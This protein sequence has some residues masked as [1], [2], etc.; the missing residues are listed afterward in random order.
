MRLQQQKTLFFAQGKSDKV[1]EISLL[2]AGDDLFVVN[3]RY[4]RRGANLQEGTKTV[5]PVPYDE[6]IKV[7]NKLIESKVKKGYNENVEESG[8]K[9]EP[10]NSSPI[11]NSAQEKTILKYLRQGSQGTYTRSWKMSRILWKAGELRLSSAA[12]L[13]DYFVFSE[14]E[15][16]QYSAIYALQKIGPEDSLEKILKVFHLK[17]FEDKSGRI[18]AA[19]I[20]LSNNEAYISAVVSAAKQKL[21]FNWQVIFT[22]PEESIALFS[23]YYFKGGI[24][25]E[26]VIYY[27]YLASYNNKK[28]REQLFIFLQDIPLKVNSFKSIRYIFRA[29]EVL[30]DVTFFALIAKRIAISPL[31][32]EAQYIYIDRKYVSVYKEKQKDNPSIAFSAKTR[33][34]FNRFIYKF[35]LKLSIRNEDDFVHF[36]KELF[37]LLDD[38]VDNQNITSEYFYDL[39][40]GRYRQKKRYFPKY[41]SFLGLM[42]V[43]YGGS[44]RIN[45]RKNKFYFLD[46]LNTKGESRDEI[47]PDIWN[48]RPLDVLSILAKSKSDVVINFAISIIEDNEGFVDQVTDD[49]LGQLIGHYDNR[50][51]NLFLQ[52]VENRYANNQAPSSIIIS[53]LSATSHKANELGLNWL[54]NDESH[55]FINSM[56]ISELLLSRKGF[57]I[58]YLKNMYQEQ[59]KYHL[60]ID[61]YLLEPLFRVPTNYN[62]DY[63]VEVCSLIG[64]T[65]FGKLLANTPVERIT[66]LSKSNI[67]NKLFALNLSKHNR[68]PAYE[69]FKDSYNEYISSD[70]LLLRKAGIELLAFFPD[71]FLLEQQNT[72]VKYCF[73]EHPEVREAIL[74]TVKRLTKIDSGFDKKFLAELLQSIIV[75]ETHE[76]IHESNYRLIIE[77]YGSYISSIDKKGIMELLLSKYEFAQKVGFPLFQ[78]KVIIANLDTDQ[79]VSLTSCDIL[80]VRKMVH[81]FFEEHVSRINFE[82]E[83]A[84]KIFNSEWQDVINWGCEY[85]ERNIDEKNWTIDV[86][87]SVCDHINPFVQSFG[88]RM[89]SIYFT[90]DKG[91]PLLLKLQEHPTKEMQFFVTNY[92]DGFAKDSP[93]VILKM[94]SYFKTSLFNINTNRPT[95]ERIYSFLEQESI[96]NINV[97]EMTIRIIDSILGTKTK[98]DISHNIDLL[99]LINES[100]P[101]LDIPLLINPV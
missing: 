45:I 29:A 97:A 33:H 27:T 4:G 3:F 78:E 7:Y 93:D 60:S 17:G 8:L 96:K 42:Y 79:I 14:D 20:L 88:R 73:S 11:L 21:P 85:F 61:I 100:H 51:A 91:L 41:H 15:F 70:E 66:S 44:N 56:F 22:H 84:L 5:F 6:A 32:Y 25:D 89:I 58:G 80:D 69:I 16:E 26:Y 75:A 82:L 10:K 9:K 23:L 68:T 30:N 65:H 47:F 72:I 53:L 24:I 98:V 38:H 40:D 19:T 95:K 63:L 76:G 64:E 46:E 83:K 94:E 81:T 54:K 18:A 92:L 2:D 87:L 37:A 1:Y 101:E 86:L 35:L 62:P 52:V 31:G 59:V 57:V 48:N 50:V 13:I 71:D 90:K 12:S 99:I 36:V 43:L 74:P 55:Y 67:T 34:Y 49:L 28:L 77:I 39:V